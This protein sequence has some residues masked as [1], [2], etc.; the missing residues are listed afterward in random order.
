[1]LS[2]LQYG[3]FADAGEGNKATMS[4]AKQPSAMLLDA[5]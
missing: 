5:D 1:M 4:N 3:F 2:R